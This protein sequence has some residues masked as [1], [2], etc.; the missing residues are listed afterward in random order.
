[1]NDSFSKLTMDW[2]LHEL[3]T[4]DRSRA[5]HTPERS[6]NEAD[7]VSA[8]CLGARWPG[9]RPLAALFYTFVS[10]PCHQMID[11]VCYMGQARSLLI[12]KDI[13]VSWELM[14][15]AR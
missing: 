6:E 11:T 14:R 12:D 3:Q 2:R 10:W 1:M 15:A 13:Q 9:T 4:P 8:A 5:S 7:T